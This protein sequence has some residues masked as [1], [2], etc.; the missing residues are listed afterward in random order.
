M[1]SHLT[2]LPSVYALLLLLVYAVSL[3]DPP[4]AVRQRRF[5]ADFCLI[6]PIVLAP[7]HTRG[8]LRPSSCKMAAADPDA[9]EETAMHSESHAFEMQSKPSP[10][11]LVFAA[12]CSVAS[13]L[14]S[15]S[16]LDTFMD[17][18]GLYILIALLSLALAVLAI[19]Y[20]RDR[21]PSLPTRILYCVL[22]FAYIIWIFLPELSTLEV[23][24]QVVV[25]SVLLKLAFL[26]LRPVLLLVCGIGLLLKKRLLYLL[27]GIIVIVLCGIDCISYFFL[28]DSPSTLCCLLFE[29]SML[30]MA[31]W[32]VRCEG[33]YE[34]PASTRSSDAAASPNG[35]KPR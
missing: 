28:L 23:T 13:L 31:L 25:F 22:A 9:Y 3:L 18:V 1:Y 30:L 26:F 24:L 8:H 29:L 14:L 10:A 2:C 5:G 7:I 20:Q 35:K 11:L 6:D 16:D 12:L 27:V 21:L 34:L 33:F 17:Y 32:A 15:L 19:L 4:K